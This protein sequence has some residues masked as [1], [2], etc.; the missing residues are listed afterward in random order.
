MF[1]GHS[2]LPSSRDEHSAIVKFFFGFALAVFEIEPGNVI[3]QQAHLEAA[4]V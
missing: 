4:C 1:I 3:S 2:P